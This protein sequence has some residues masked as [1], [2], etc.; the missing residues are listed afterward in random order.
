MSSDLIKASARE[1][2]AE[3]R[4]DI[5]LADYRKMKARY[6]DQIKEL[7]RDKETEIIV[8]VLL[9]VYQETVRAYM[10]NGTSDFFNFMH[11]LASE[12]TRKDYT[13]MDATYFRKY[14]RESN[15]P[16][17]AELAEVLRTVKIDNP[18]AHKQ[19]DDVFKIGLYDNTRNKVV[20]FPQVSVYLYE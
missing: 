6:E 9:P 14:N 2:S 17:I 10:N 16:E 12:I 4:Y 20:A 19:I 11:M 8:K 3:E 13:L 15:K 1:M 18:R 7:S 5:L